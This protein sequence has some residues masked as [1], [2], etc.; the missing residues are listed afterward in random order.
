MKMKFMLTFEWKEG[1]KNQEEGI[2]RF[3]K[4]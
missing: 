4:G 1:T 3:A 2:A